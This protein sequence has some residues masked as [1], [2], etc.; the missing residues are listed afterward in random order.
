MSQAIQWHLYENQALS[1]T[2]EKLFREE[3]KQLLR[4]HCGV[5]LRL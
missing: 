5:G 2:L 3:A 4:S 1:H